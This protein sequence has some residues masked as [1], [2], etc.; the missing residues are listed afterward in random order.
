MAASTITRDTWTNDSGSFSTPAGDGTVL[1]NTVLQNHIYARIDAMFA[2]AGSYT[3]FH[4]GG[5]FAVE[6]FGSSTF[7]A[8]GTGVQQLAVRNTTAGTG[9][10]CE[11]AIGHDSTAR[12]TVLQAYSTTFSTTS[13][14][15]ADGTTLVGTG[16]GGMSIVTTNASG[17]LR[18]YTN[19]LPRFELTPAGAF[20]INGTASL[21]SEMFTVIT[22]NVG[23][24]VQCTAGTNDGTFMYF[25]NSVNGVAGSITQTG[26]TTVAYNTTSDARLK[27]DHGKAQDLSALRG[28][29]IHDF[30]W[31]IDG[32]KDRGVFAQEA[33]DVLPEAV[34]RGGDEMTKDLSQPSSP[35]MMNYSKLIPH[36]VAGWQ[37]HDAVIAS[38]QARIARLEAA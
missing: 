12:L 9:N 3:T 36:L 18:F 21:A 37:D 8:G 23:I 16:A 11:V 26:A 38:L 27:T 14:A 35:W 1:A 2:G 20:V 32:T 6:G 22:A 17:H 28:L 29:I 5:L 4:L 34:T 7:S 13:Y 33:I 10:Y 19:S 31:T 24:T 25:R 15:V 30:I